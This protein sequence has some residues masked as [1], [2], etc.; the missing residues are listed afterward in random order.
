MEGIHVALGLIILKP[1]EIRRCP[2]PGLKSAL[3]VLVCGTTHVSI[4]LIQSK[5]PACLGH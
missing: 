5:G 2:R 4:I 3:A 1:F